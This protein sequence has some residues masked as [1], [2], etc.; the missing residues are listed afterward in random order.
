MSSSELA[1][2]LSAKT[3]VLTLKVADIDKQYVLH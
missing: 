2:K 1:F 3:E